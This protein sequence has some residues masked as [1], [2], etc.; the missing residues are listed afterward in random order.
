MTFN[1]ELERTRQEAVMV[2]AKVLSYHLQNHENCLSGCCASGKAEAYHGNLVV[3]SG[4]QGNRWGMDGRT[5]YTSR[6]RNLTKHSKKRKQLSK[7]PM[8]HTLPCSADRS[9]DS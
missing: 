2:F 5:R 7:N 6:P 4:L 8:M 1:E 3:A 9:S